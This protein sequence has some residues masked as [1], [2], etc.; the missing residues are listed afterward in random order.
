MLM[1]N[2]LPTG[3]RCAA[4][5][6]L[7]VLSSLALQAL[8]QAPA[9]AAPDDSA[10]CTPGVRSWVGYGALNVSDAPYSGTWKVTFDQKLSDGKLVHG[11]TRTL[12]AR[13]SDGKLRSEASVGCSLDKDGHV[14]QQLTVHILDPTA[15]TFLDWSIGGAV[16]KVAHQQYQPERL[17]WSGG[18]SEWPV[19]E[20]SSSVPGKSV[21]TT[22]VESLGTKMI[23]GIQAQG[24]RLTATT[25]Y[26]NAPGNP[27]PSV[28]V[29]ERWIS[30]E[31]GLLLSDLVDD[32]DRGRT[33]AVMENLSLKEPDPSLFVPPSGYTLTESY[34]KATIPQ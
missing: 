20:R 10:P 3:L 5:L 6:A 7:G 32:P 28:T 25:I 1:R 4:P 13:S 26:L 18:I 22:R 23:A 2:L 19:G 21:T 14:L 9:T 8:S 17:T 15:G 31:H 33:E 12:S 27:N 16:L 11:V 24:Q 34:P 29:H 30:I